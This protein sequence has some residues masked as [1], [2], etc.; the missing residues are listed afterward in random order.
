MLGR[1][2]IALSL[3]ALVAFVFWFAFLRDAGPPA[4]EL[5]GSDRVFNTNDPLKRACGLSEEMLVRLWRGHHPVH[6]EDI[7]TVPQEPNYSGSFGVTSHSGPWDYVQTIPLVF[8]GP[9]HITAE[10]RVLDKAASITDV[11]PTIASLLGIELPPREGTSLDDM[12]VEPGSRPRLIVSIVWDGVG[13]NVLQRHPDAWPVLARLERGGTSYLHATVGSSPSITPATHSSLGTGAFPSEHAVTAIEFRTR[14]GEV[15]GAFAGKDP[16]DL[17]LST[18]ADE[19]DLA[20]DNEPKVGMLAWKSWHLGMLGHGR[21]LSGG[22]SDEMVLINTH[23]QLT[24]NEQ[25]FSFPAKLTGLEPRLSFFAR[26]VDAEDGTLDGKI[27]GREVLG[28]HDNPAWVYYQTELL[29]EML[30]RGGYG[31][32]DVPDLF[33]TNFKITD[34]V[35]HQ[36]SMDSKEEAAVLEAQDGALG[37]LLTYLNSNVGDYVVI[38]TADHGNTPSPERSGAWP[39]LQGQLQEDVDAHFDVP[40]GRSLIEKTSA[41]GP[42]LDRETMQDL[43]VSEDD[44]AGFLNSYTIKD[45]LNDSMLPEG[46][47]DRG[48]EHVFSAAF[49]ADDIDEALKCARG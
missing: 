9:N 28:M 11:Y 21:Q 30:K 36:F 43:D 46:Y 10:T 6:S 27:D 13:R 12:L 8:Y 39:I 1:R 32:D 5:A 35:S 42:F 3:V 47:E 48:E 2:L 19:A 23:G 15:R 18:F 44:V 26:K 7:T 16:A 17:E 14:A 4:Q 41:A 38:V 22:D 49:P 29:I 33:F 24:G 31:K 45:N 20:L 34:I 37:D 40:K 25:Y